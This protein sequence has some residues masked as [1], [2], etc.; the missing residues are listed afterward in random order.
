LVDPRVP[1]LRAEIGTVPFECLSAFEVDTLVEIFETFRGNCLKH[2][3]AD[4]REFVIEE[5]SADQLSRVYAMSEVDPS[6]EGRYQPFAVYAASPRPTGS[7]AR[8]D[9][10][11]A[12]DE[13]PL[14]TALRARD[15]LVIGRYKGF[16]VLI[17]GYFR[18]LLFMR[19]ASSGERVA[20]MVPVPHSG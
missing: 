11:V 20:V 19:S 4:V 5:W 13:V 16:Q 17:D 2:Y 9:P 8:L 3:W 14:T 12:A 18:G 1:A 6:G 7:S 10:R 15:P